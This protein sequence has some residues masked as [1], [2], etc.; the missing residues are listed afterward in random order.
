RD[1]KN[2]IA[3]IVALSPRTLEIVRVDNGQMTVMGRAT[4]KP[5]NGP[6]HLL[7]VQRINFAHV[8]RPRISIFFD[9]QESLAV[10]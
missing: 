7:R 3:A 4:V 5:Q 10:M 2:F 8:S 9:G 6:W 1:A